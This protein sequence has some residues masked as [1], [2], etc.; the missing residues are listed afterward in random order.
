MVGAG[1]ALA[2]LCLLGPDDP[3]QFEFGFAAAWWVAVVVI[4]RSDLER[5]IIPDG[6][7]ASVAALGLA[8]AVAAPLRAGFGSA[9]ASADAA[10]ALLTGGFAF[11]LFWGI[12]AAYRR[13]RGH[14][15]LG[16]GDVKLA[17]AS[18]LWLTPADATLAL[19]TAAVAGLAVLL[20][21]RRNGVHHEAALPFGAFLAP[22]AWLAFVAG[23]VLHRVAERLG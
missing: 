18:A 7:S 16:F 23:P 2:V 8:Y 3:L 22:A 14:E 1:L 20:W 19:E 13:I 6:A 9:V 12:A 5:L 10:A 17:G 11:A 4:V 21:R 15:G